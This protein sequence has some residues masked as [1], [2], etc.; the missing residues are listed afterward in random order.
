MKNV[1]PEASR[2]FRNI[3]REYLKGNINELTTNSRKMNIEE[4]CRRINE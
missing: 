4:L 3:K 1:M 2:H